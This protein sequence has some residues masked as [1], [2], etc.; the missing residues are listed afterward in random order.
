M[1]QGEGAR[2]RDPVFVATA[3]KSTPPQRQHPIPKH[4]QTLEV[5]WDR[6]IVE[7]ALD[8]RLEPPSGSGHGIVH[9]S[10][11]LLLNLSQFAPHPLADRSAPYH[12]AS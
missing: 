3:A 10:A 2:P 5:S 12:E 8:D 4:P 11:K 6:V 1:S 7:V 9:A